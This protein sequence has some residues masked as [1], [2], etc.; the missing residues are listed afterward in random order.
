MRPV[1][2]IGA[3]PEVLVA[4]R[5]QP[6]KH[7]VDLGLAGDEGVEGLFVVGGR[8]MAVSCMGDPM[9]ASI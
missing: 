4:Q 7:R 1:D 2:L 8:R 9:N 3:V 5:L 6:L